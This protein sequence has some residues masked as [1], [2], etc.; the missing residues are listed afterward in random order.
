LAFG[1]SLLLALSTV[2]VLWVFVGV[3]ALIAQLAATRRLALQLGGACVALALLARVVADTAAGGGWLRWLTPLGWAEEQRPFTGERPLVLLLP[4]TVGA[5]LLVLAA[6]FARRRDVGCG[7]LAPRERSAP[8]LAL[9]GSPT[10]Q[11]LRAELAALLTWMAGAA[12]F[13]FII[14]VLAKSTASA[15]LSVQLRRELAKLGA[16]SITTPAGYVGLSFLLFELVVPLFA[17]TQVAALAREESDQA[18]ETLLALP[19]GRSRWLA[20]RWALAA[21]GS[22]AVALT[23]VLCGWIGVSASGASLSLP[24][25]LEA[26]AN[27]MA[28]A[29]L[30]LGIAVLLFGIAPRAAAA[31]A[32]VLVT[33]AFLWQLFGALLSVPQ[34]A[35]NLT[36]YAHLGL[37]PAQPFRPLPALILALIGAVSAVAGMVAF[38]RRD[39]AQA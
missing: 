19:V 26:G 17:V 4:L 28:M 22:A 31:G 13:A 14:G 23:A 34:W 2:S 15:G 21:G 25:M 9:L 5:A 35:L 3:G 36:P 1:D 39:L 37:A 12:G 10:A 6:R 38:R 24:K 30:F 7:A 32:Y 16:G 29:A 8:R 20:G 11:A 18:L 27:C 33:L